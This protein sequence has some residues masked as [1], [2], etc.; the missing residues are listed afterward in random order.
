MDRVS[1]ETGAF[2]TERPGGETRLRYLDFATGQSSTIAH[3][4]G[5]VGP[6]PRATPDGRM[7]FSRASTLPTTS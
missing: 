3:N 7:I 4:L 6:G 2:F 1:G 5:T